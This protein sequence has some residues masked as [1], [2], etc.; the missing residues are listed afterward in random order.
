M[1]DVILA[2][3]VTK[4]PTANG[5]RYS[6]I[7]EGLGDNRT[8]WFDVSSTLGSHMPARSDDWILLSLLIL[9]MNSGRNLRVEGRLS[10]LL[11]HG[12]RSDIQH[13]LRKFDP[14]LSF[15]EVEGDVCPQQ[16]PAC[17]RLR[18][19][20]GFS[21]GIDS[22]AAA[23][24]FDETGLAPT[25]AVTDVFTFNVGALG[26][27]LG[28]NTRRAFAL[29]FE[30]AKEFSA[31]SGATA[32]GV[33]SNLHTFYT[34]QPGMEFPRT[35]TLRNMAAASLFQSEIDCYL[36]A[37]GISYGEMNLASA[38][39]IANFDPILLPL[40]APAG[41]RFIS[42]NP[43]LDRVKKTRAV[44]ANEL[45][46]RMLDV[47]VAPTAAR[48]EAIRNRRNCSRCWK[49]YRTMVT[50]DALEQLDQFAQ[51]FDVDYYRE[52]T[53]GI[54]RQVKKRGAKGSAPDKAAYDCYAAAK[55]VPALHPALDQ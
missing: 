5:A 11:L 19:G 21:A 47:C 6:C 23:S 54:V 50:L 36:Y 26:G 32:H 25:L 53:D 39:D 44:S 48:A 15:I 16:P 12:A 24:S 43:G 27:G 31:L 10:P 18:I 20:T 29:I 13:L 17:E 51:V 7:V 55:L 3:A 4:L 28:A 38:S 8:L 46:R 22:F 40:L 9:A 14:R 49:C 37:S 30:R 33:D 34:G 1:S 35:H 52:R 2:R 42:A 45:A 41:M